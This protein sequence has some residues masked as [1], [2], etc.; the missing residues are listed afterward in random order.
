[1]AFIYSL[2][3]EFCLMVFICMGVTILKKCTSSRETHLVFAL[4]ISAGF[5]AFCDVFAYTAFLPFKFFNQDFYEF[6]RLVKYVSLYSFTPIMLHIILCKSKPAL[7]IKYDFLNYIIY[8]PSLILIAADLITVRYFKYIDI[9]IPDY[10]KIFN[11]VFH[12]ILIMLLLISWRR[13]TGFV[14]EKKQIFIILACGFS[15][16]AAVLIYKLTMAS[17]LP[18]PDFSEIFLLA[19]ILGIW[20]AISRYNFIGITELIKSEEIIEKVNDFIFIADCKKNIIKVNYSLLVNLGFKKSELIG[21]QYCKL[22]S[23]D[24]DASGLFSGNS[25]DNTYECDMV[26]V[27]GKSIPVVVKPRIIRDVSGDTAG[28]LVICQDM[29]TVRELQLEVSQRIRNELQLNYLGMHDALTGLHNRTYFEQEIQKLEQSGRRFIGIMICDVDGLKIINDTLGHAKGDE[30]LKKTTK[31]L[32]ESKF[33][34]IV[35]ARI[36]GDEF[37]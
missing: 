26:T 11:Y 35:I 6:L 32:L 29:R 3:A 33:E 28:I 20:F 15:A 14:L 23:A 4:C 12:G 24:F 27:S 8:L 37:A 34:K 30:L 18:V 31:L 5:L 2:V 21:C 17:V 10:I 7:L 36:G 1:M 9:H 25:T 22:F 16:L 19:T 13:N